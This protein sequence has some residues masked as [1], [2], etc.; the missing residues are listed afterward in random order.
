MHPKGMIAPV[1]LPA[2]ILISQSLSDFPRRIRHC[3]WCPG[4][5]FFIRR[6]RRR[7]FLVVLLM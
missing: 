6:P 7:F 5:Y 3:V 2:F 4:F 1:S